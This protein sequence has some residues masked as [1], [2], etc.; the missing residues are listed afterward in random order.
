[1]P[2]MAT[3]PPGNSK[4]VIDPDR[5]QLDFESLDGQ[6]LEWTGRPDR[7]TAYI[8]MTGA[9]GLRVPPRRVTS[10]AYAGMDGERLL[11]VSTGPREVTLPVCVAADDRQVNSHLEQLARI[12]TF[13][14]Y[15]GMDYAALDGTFD[16]LATQQDSV[17]QRRLR[18]IYLDGMEGSEG[19]ADGGW[20]YLSRFAVKL[21]AVDPYWHGDEWSTPVVSLPTQLPFLADSG[22]AHPLRLATPVALGTNMPV[23]VGGDVPSSAIVELRGPAT[24]TIITSPSGLNVTIGALA[25]GQS[26]L[27]DTNPRNRRALL[28]GV[29]GPPG[30]SKVG[31]GPQWRPLPPGA[32]TVSIV[33]SGA[34]AQ[35]SARVYGTDLWETAW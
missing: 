23:T 13:I 25:A 8:I 15:R 33:M 14:D 34:T 2:I 17:T 7:A 11:D 4:P 3:L 9:T 35:S 21:R 5:R 1:M 24:Q 32:G 27:L 19:Y 29:G 31:A 6:V 30:W 22:P 12:R 20:T 28:N 10:E 26:F 16:L 18:C